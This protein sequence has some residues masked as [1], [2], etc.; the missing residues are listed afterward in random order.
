VQNARS[1][2]QQNFDGAFSRAQLYP[3]KHRQLT[4]KTFI[5]NDLELQKK[6]Q[7]DIEIPLHS[8]HPTLLRQHVRWFPMSLMVF[9]VVLFIC[10]TSLLS[11]SCRRSYFLLHVWHVLPK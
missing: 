9:Y 4:I 10:F 5:A 7:I 11:L 1:I 2:E 6:K 3:Q 8:I